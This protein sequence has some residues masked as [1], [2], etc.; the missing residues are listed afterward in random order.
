[1][2]RATKV[3][4][5][6]AVSALLAGCGGS[7]DDGAT[8]S[9]STATTATQAGTATGPAT[10]ASGATTG[11]VPTTTAEAGTATSASGGEGAYAATYERECAKLVRAVDGYT[12]S[13]SGP[14]PTAAERRT[15]VA[16]YKRETADLLVVLRTMFRTLAATGA[17]AQYAEFQRSI[18]AV[19]PQVDLKVDRALKV[20][21]GIRSARDTP[22]A[23]QDVKRALSSI[24]S[25]AFPPALRRQAPSCQKFG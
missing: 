14:P 5:V 19:V 9:A 11:T 4:S 12:R 7:D 16:R 25:D 23:G 3:L 22:D 6:L 24:S 21:E 15:I 1:M 17:P 8:T 10:V 20:V 2:I 18:V 13:F